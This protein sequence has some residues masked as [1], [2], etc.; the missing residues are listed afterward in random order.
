MKQTQETL[1]IHPAVEVAIE[2]EDFGRVIR[3]RKDIKP[4]PSV[5][6]AD[7][8]PDDYEPGA[9]ITVGGVATRIRAGTRIG[10]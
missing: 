5:N 9:F 3:S 8:S 4:E 7:A 6:R 1:T 10:G 2:P